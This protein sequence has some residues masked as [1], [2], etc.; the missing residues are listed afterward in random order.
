MSELHRKSCT[1]RNKYHETTKTNDHSK[2]WEA[3]HYSWT[4]GASPLVLSG[5]SG[6][7]LTL[8]GGFLT[9]FVMP[10]MFNIG[11][12][13]YFYNNPCICLRGPR[14]NAKRSNIQSQGLDLYMGLCKYEAGGLSTQLQHID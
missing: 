6:S 14:K 12:H 11:T 4:H 7:E 9:Q 1:K 10:S 3:T 8:M 5:A 13:I 2:L